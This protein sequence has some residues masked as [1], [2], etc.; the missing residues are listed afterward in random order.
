VLL[1]VTD[2]GAVHAARFLKE[3]DDRKEIEGKLLVSVAS[4]LP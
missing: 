4:S 2:R 3:M 1:D